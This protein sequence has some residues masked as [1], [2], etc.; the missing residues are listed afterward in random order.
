M[1]NPLFAW[2]IRNQLGRRNLPNYERA[3]LALQ[4]KPL[5]AEEAKKKQSESGG[6]VP[7][8]SV[9]PPVDV[10]KELAKI[11]GVPHDTIHKVDV[12]EQKATWPQEPL[13]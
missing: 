7:Q 4:L 5:L 12:I 1:C 10:Q 13:R 3:R 9:K 6:A 8:K 11:A 2:M